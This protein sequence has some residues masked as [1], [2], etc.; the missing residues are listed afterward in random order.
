[1]ERLNKNKGKRDAFKETLSLS[2]DVKKR[3]RYYRNLRREM[4]I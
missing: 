4:A 1:M 2:N 3:P